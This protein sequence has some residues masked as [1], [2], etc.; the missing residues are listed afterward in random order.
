MMVM[1]QAVIHMLTSY[2]WLVDR[3]IGIPR[4]RG[5]A[6]GGELRV[7][8]TTQERGAGSNRLPFL[9]AHL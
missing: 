9:K 1:E 8:V 7:G 4:G 2:G 5:V 6:V 3:R